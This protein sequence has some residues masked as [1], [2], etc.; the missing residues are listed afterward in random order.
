LE[1]S[2][3]T[4]GAFDITVAPLVSL[5]GFGAHARHEDINEQQIAIERAR[6]GY[7]R[8]EVEP[9]SATLRKRDDDVMCDLSGI[10]KGY[11]IDELA[12]YLRSGGYPN[13][14][15]EV[16]GDVR[17]GG[18]NLRGQP[19]QIGI[20]RPDTQ[21]R[22]IFEVLPLDNLAL[23][24]SGDY[25]NYREVNGQRISHTIDP[26]TGRPITHKLASVSVAHPE[27]AMADALATGLNVLG[28]SEGPVLAESLGLAALFLVRTPDGS[29]ER[30]ATP[31]FERLVERPL[32]AQESR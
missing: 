12:K 16:G 3:K 28:P 9:S 30:L 24:T 17:T 4:H 22:A 6:V 31:E 21:A 29:F 14:M 26:R 15:I 23:A 27:A 8:I 25:R 19:W 7:R 1:A 32:L 10:A 20:E 13:F 5:W 11:A 2:R 18:T